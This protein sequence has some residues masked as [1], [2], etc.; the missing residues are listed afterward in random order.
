MCKFK[1]EGLF[2][3]FLCKLKAK[4]IGK[5]VELQDCDTTACL[6]NRSKKNKKK[7]K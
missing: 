5:K 6:V 3:C 2:G 1:V 7:I 4:R